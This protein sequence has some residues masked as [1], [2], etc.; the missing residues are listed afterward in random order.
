MQMSVQKRDRDEADVVQTEEKQ[1]KLD[2][3]QARLDEVLLDACRH[4]SLS[5]IEAAL[6][7]GASINA[8]TAKG[9]TGLSLAC[10]RTDWEVALLI[11]KLLLAKRFAPSMMN[12]NGWNALHVAVRHSSAGLV[13]VVLGKMQTTIK[14]LTNTR[15]SALALYCIRMTRKQ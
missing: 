3:E 15:Y 8:T 13:A 1:A 4:G 10:E 6:K 14:V 9:G 2:E 7:D 11:V 5:D 12:Q